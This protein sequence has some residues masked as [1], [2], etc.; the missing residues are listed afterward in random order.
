[1][2]NISL[3]LLVT[4]LI[5]L[6]GC[7]G[8]KEEDIEPYKG[9]SYFPVTVGHE[10]IYSVK[11]LVLDEFTG[12]WDTADYKIREVIEST[13]KDLENRETQRIERYIK[14]DTTN[15]NFVIYKVW[16]ANL[17]TSTAHRVEDN[18]RY[19]KLTFP[20]NIGQTWN[21]NSLNSLNAQYYK[22]TALH[23]ALSLNGLNYDSTCTILQLMDSDLTKNLFQQESYAAK[24]GMIYKINQ[25]IRYGGGGQVTSASIYTETLDS[26][27]R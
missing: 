25:D 10:L 4:I 3:I 20:Q 7:K 12:T 11:H 16:A 18:I 9:K 22:Y 2:K 27:I 26:F 24:V 15:G 13:Y 21:A 5:S 19:I 6:S 17:L 1:M 23:E 8:I 14:N